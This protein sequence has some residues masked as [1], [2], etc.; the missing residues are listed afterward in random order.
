ME[1]DGTETTLLHLSQ[2]CGY[3]VEITYAS[4]YQ[5]HTHTHVHVHV[6]MQRHSHVG[7]NTISKLISY[8]QKVYQND[9]CF[10]SINSKTS[11]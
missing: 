7:F 5:T 9:L 10:F 6:R 11:G 1:T 2:Y 3:N 4:D 8:C